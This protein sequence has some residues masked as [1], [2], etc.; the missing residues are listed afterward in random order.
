MVE[1]SEGG[2]VVD[3]CPECQAVWF[4]PDEISKY[5]KARKAKAVDGVSDSD[6][7][8]TA[9]GATETCPCCDKPSFQLGS[10]RGIAFQRCT[11][12]GGIFL[13][14]DQL[15]SFIRSKEGQVSDSALTSEEIA[16]G[17]AGM[18]LEVLIGG[19]FPF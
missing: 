2:V 9:I 17:A 16:K 1:V 15:K 19:L 13:N 18:F 12:C 4:D 10:F 6:F 5:L 8:V 7:R 3:K 14:S 11:W